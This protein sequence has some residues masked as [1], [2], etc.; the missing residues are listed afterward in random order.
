MSSGHIESRIDDQKSARKP[1]RK[2][3]RNA[4][5]WRLDGKESVA[6]RHLTRFSMLTARQLSVATGRG[7]RNSQKALA[8]LLEKDL[9]CFGGLLPEDLNLDRPQKPERAFSLT[10]GGVKYVEHHE[11][12]WSLIDRKSVA[13]SWGGRYIQDN[14]IRHKLGIVD[15]MIWLCRS[16]DTFKDLE[17]TYLAPDFIRDE[18]QTSINKSA[19]GDDRLIPDIVACVL[20]KATGASRTLFVEYDRGHE[21]VWLKEEKSKRGYSINGKLEKYNRYFGGKNRAVND[22]DPA[23]LFVCESEKRVQSIRN[24]ERLRWEKWGNLTKRFKLASRDR[25]SS[26]FLE[27]DWHIPGTDECFPI[28]ERT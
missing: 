21:P 14:E 20:N 23:L 2:R 27:A 6:I 4:V 1:V 10:E 15:C 11:C 22:D 16:V 28:V 8:G 26:A 25:V 5:T 18:D 3:S 17:V 24:S 13:R 12:S 9:A 19:F 7:L